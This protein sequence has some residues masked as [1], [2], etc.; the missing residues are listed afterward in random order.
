[1]DNSLLTLM[2]SS[3]SEK[4]IPTMNIYPF[5]SFPFQL[6]TCENGPVRLICRTIFLLAILLVSASFSQARTATFSWTANAD[7]VDGYKLNYK[8]ATSGGPPYSTVLDIGNA[9]TYTLEGLALDQTYYFALTA[10][11]GTEV[12]D[13][14]DEVVL[15][16]IVAETPPPTPV[17]AGLSFSKK[18]NAPLVVDFDGSSSTGPPTSYNWNFGDG[19]IGTGVAVSHTFPTKGDYTITLTVASATNQDATSQAIRLETDAVNALPLAVLSSDIA[20]GEAPLAVNFDASQSSDHD[21]DPLSYSWD[22]GDGTVS[23]S[24]MNPTHIFDTPGTYS[25]SLSVN[26]GRGGISTANSPLIVTANSQTSDPNAIPSAAI[27]FVKSTASATMGGTVI[28]FAGEGSRPS[29]DGGAIISY[30][31]DFGD[32]SALATGASPRH[33]YAAIATYTVTLMVTDNLG[34]QATALVDIDLNAL[35]KTKVNITPILQLLLLE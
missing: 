17:S 35:Q 10:Y 31:W 8:T 27:T 7:Q 21:N 3:P 20:T 13:F 22:F 16:A 24:G 18:A 6:Q 19:S 5:H 11:R 12:S 23:V 34:K 33:E 32:G 15:S 4:V 29:T 30:K 14:S 9:T 28:D 2:E 26:D 25:V 1:M